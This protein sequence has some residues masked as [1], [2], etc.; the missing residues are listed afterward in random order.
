MPIWFI[1]ATAVVLSTISLT[2]LPDIV[3]VKDLKAIATL[4][5][6]FLSN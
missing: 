1:V 2:C 5:Q 6:A 3:V 4:L